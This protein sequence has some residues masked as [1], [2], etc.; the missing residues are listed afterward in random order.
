MTTFNKE[1]IDIVIYHGNCN[2]G[3]ASAFAVWSYF[4]IA[5]PV[6][7][8][9]QIEYV[10]ASFD[11]KPPS[12][13]G[14]NVLICDFSYKKPVLE[15]MIIEAKS[16]MIIDHHKTAQEDLRDIP[17]QY[18]IFDMNHCGAYLTWQFIYASSCPIPLLINYIEDRD[19]WTKKLE[20]T[21][22]FA[23]L[24][25]MTAHEFTEWHDFLESDILL[26]AIKNRGMRYYEINQYNIDKI[27]F[28]VCPKFCQIKG[29]YYLIGYVNSRILQSDIGNKAFGI[30]PLLS[31]SAVYY[32]DDWDDRTFFSLRSLDENC[33][34]STVAKH[35]G[36]GGHRNASGCAIDHVTNVLPAKIYGGI[37]LYHLLEKVYLGDVHGTNLKVIYLISDQYKKQLGYFLLQDR[38]DKGTQ[39]GLYFYNKVNKQNITGKLDV[40]AIWNITREY[41][42]QHI[43][44]VFRNEE[45]RKI[46]MVAYSLEE[47]CITRS[48]MGEDVDYTFLGEH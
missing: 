5:K 41:P 28:K 44:L 10:A 21:D 39:N 17:D 13:I 25:D 34:V 2:D 40:A 12:V 38:D 26:S 16:L 3:F 48:I 9:R 24:M 22:A 35:F 11:K 43:Q 14:K 4:N 7:E 45:V 15:R 32:I 8:P 30:F 36:G 6:D 33:D 47:D 1:E 29:K 37:N 31:F 20:N 27:A 19:L 42:Q 23:A 46:I 18:K